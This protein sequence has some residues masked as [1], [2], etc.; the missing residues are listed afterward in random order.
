MTMYNTTTQTGTY[1][2]V[3]IKKAFEGFAADF[4][5]IAQRTEKMSSALVEQ[6]LNDITAWAEG[7]Y[8]EYVDIAL[9]DSNDK[10]IKATRFTI[11]E[12]GKATQSDRAGGNDWPNSPNT[13]LVIIL[14]NSDAWVALGTEKQQKFMIDKNFKIQWG[15]SK[16][17]NSYSHLS[18]Q[19]AQLYASK[20]YELKKDNFK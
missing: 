14:Q 3:D 8:L 10:P 17:D 4:R 18:K 6:Y 2:V 15:E 13:R 11:D 9:V 7:K 12:S 1:T 19:G 5:M 16:I 20:G